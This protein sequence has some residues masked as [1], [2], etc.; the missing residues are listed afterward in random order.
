MHTISYH[1]LKGT[2]Q[3]RKHPVY[4]FIHFLLTFFIFLNSKSRLRSNNV[5]RLIF[6]IYVVQSFSLIASS[7]FSFFY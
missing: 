5:N 3:L 2:P 4:I 7:T 6:Y 1:M